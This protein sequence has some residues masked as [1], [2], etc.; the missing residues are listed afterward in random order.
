MTIIHAVACSCSLGSGGACCAI[1]GTM[2][3][4]DTRR[5]SLASDC[6]GKMASEHAV[7]EPVG[8]DRRRCQQRQRG[9]CLQSPGIASLG[10]LSAQRC[11]PG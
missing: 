11:A 2:T 7:E 9:I 6:D 10:F 8:D 5:L 1:C 3:L 4:I